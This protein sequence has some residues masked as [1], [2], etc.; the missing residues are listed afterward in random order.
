MSVSTAVG[1]KIYISDAVS[2]ATTQG[3]FEALT[4]IEVEQT[5]SIGEFGDDQLDEFCC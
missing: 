1:A 3:Q 4:W 5:E 2:T